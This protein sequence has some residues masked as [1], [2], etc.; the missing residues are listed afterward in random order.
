VL[1]IHDFIEYLRNNS[2]KWFDVFR[3]IANKNS[4]K[5]YKAVL[6]FIKEYIGKYGTRD[7][8]RECLA[9]IANCAWT[10]PPEDMAEANEIRRMLP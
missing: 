6:G 1:P 7:L 10:Y 3:S 9:A 8:P 4:E 2:C 5:P